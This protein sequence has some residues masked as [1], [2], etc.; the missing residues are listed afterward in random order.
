MEKLLRWTGNIIV[1][2]TKENKRKES[3]V[4]GYKESKVK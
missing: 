2:I 3:I 1:V 4:N